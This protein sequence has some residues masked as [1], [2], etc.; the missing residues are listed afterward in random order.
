MSTDLERKIELART[1]TRYVNEKGQIAVV[2]SPGFGSGWSTWTTG[3]SPLDPVIAMLVHEGRTSEITE[4]LMT[5]LGF[6]DAY[7]G[8]NVED[9]VIEW[10]TPGAV[11]RIHE[12]DGSESV[13]F[14]ASDVWRA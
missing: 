10:V 13:Q 11:F 12:Y 1:S 4:E 9:L 6:P 7:L 14:E 3:L 5:Q 2:Y 8:S